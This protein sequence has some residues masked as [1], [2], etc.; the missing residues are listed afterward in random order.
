MSSWSKFHER[1]G[2][3]T[4][5]RPQYVYGSYISDAREYERSTNQK[6]NM[7]TKVV[8]C[9]SCLVGKGGSNSNSNDNDHHRSRTKDVDTRYMYNDNGE[10]FE[11]GKLRNHYEEDSI[12]R[13]RL[14]SSGRR[15]PLTRGWS[16]SRRN[17]G[18]ISYLQ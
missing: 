1:H 3:I 15:S 8:S 5:K 14:R 7:F 17:R 12:L 11:R 4:S 9:L 13:T 10:S 16:S 18:N 6:N 2:N